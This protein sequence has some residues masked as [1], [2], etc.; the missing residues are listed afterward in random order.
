MNK[1]E[2]PVNLYATK[3]QGEGYW[4]SPW[5]DCEDLFLDIL[6]HTLFFFYFLCITT[7][8]T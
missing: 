1:G 7:P 8:L 5:G 3:T 6:N 4:G 2:V